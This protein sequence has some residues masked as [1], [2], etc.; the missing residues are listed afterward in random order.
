VKR[1]QRPPKPSPFT[2]NQ[3]RERA[4]QLWQERG[5]SASSDDNWQAAIEALKRE[6]SP[7]GQMRRALLKEF[8]LPGEKGVRAFLGNANQFLR[9]AVTAETPTAALDVMKV[10]ISGLGLLA[11]ATAGFVL[12]L[13]YQQG[14]EKLVTDRFAKSVELLGSKEI[15]VRIGAIYSLERIAK[16]SPKDHWTIMEVLTAFVRNK[17]RLP[18]DKKQKL[19]PVT[20]DVQS[21]LTAIGRREAKHD[22]K[23]YSLNLSNTSLTGA[24]LN[25]ANLEGA[26]FQG[27][28]LTDADLFAARL[29]SANLDGTSLSGAS[30][31]AADLRG[32]SMTI[33]QIKAA[34]YWQ[35][36]HYHPDRREELGLP[37]E[38]P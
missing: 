32:A 35:N 15:D 20:T 31:L 22:S 5:E 7:L 21:A 8:W 16:D 29:Q 12:Y 1:S 23:L 34:K 38:K 3:I 26:N 11:T 19:K 9:L 30:M 10:V 28:D 18:E 24:D 37:P 36:A 27:A 17:A 14:Q 6:R 25:N 13:N 4:Y 33:V 2:E